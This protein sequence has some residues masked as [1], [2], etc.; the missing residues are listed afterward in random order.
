MLGVVLVLYSAR[1]VME[2]LLVASDQCLHGRPGGS[3]VCSQ[4][5]YG[6]YQGMLQHNSTCAFRLLLCMFACILC[7]NSTHLWW[8]PSS[9]N[10]LLD[11]RIIAVSKY[12]MCSVWCCEI[13]WLQTCLQLLK[14]VAIKGKRGWRTNYK[15][16]YWGHLYRVNVFTGGMI[17]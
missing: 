12:L 2:I 3:Y 13:A 9:T 6:H 15:N 8:G 1:F 5:W 17:I 4:F 10:Y 11:T 7:S 16:C 14:K